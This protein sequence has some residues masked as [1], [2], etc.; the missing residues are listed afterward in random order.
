MLYIVVPVYNR[1]KDTLKILDA[2]AQ[3]TYREYQVIVVNDGSTDG[4]SEKVN[5]CFPATK[6]LNTPGDYWWSATINEGVQYAISV[7]D[8]TSDYIMIINNDVDFPD[9]VLARMTKTMEGKKDRILN[10]IRLDNSGNGIVVSSG[11][12]VISWWLALHSHSYAGR[13]ASTLEEQEPS[14]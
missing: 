14:R 4:T 1:V 11:G 2:F 9:D 12:K 13:N 10:P 6:I 5:Q 7:G 8:Q 3:Q